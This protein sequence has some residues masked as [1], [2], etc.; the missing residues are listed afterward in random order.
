VTNQSGDTTTALSKGLFWV[1]GIT[2]RTKPLFSV[3]AS[4]LACALLG[5]RHLLIPVRAIS[6]RYWD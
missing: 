5:E 4:R 2:Y 6:R 1:A 3:R